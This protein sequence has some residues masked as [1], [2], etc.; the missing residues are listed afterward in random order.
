MNHSVVGRDMF[1]VIVQV[2]VDV[3]LSVANATKLKLSATVAA[4]LV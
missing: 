1:D 3:K 4:I 2:L